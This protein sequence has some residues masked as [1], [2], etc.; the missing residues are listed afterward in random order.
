MSMHPRHPPL[1]ITKPSLEEIIPCVS[2][3]LAKAIAD[4]LRGGEPPK[5]RKNEWERWAITVRAMGY[6]LERFGFDRT[7]FLNS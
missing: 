7:Q 1:G 3:R 2:L 6:T 4:T 5:D